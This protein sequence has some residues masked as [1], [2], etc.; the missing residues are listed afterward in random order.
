MQQG[1]NQCEQRPVSNRAEQGP[2]SSMA[3]QKLGCHT[4]GKRLG[5][6]YY[7]STPGGLV[8]YQLHTCSRTRINVQLSENSAVWYV[9]NTADIAFCHSKW[10]GETRK[11]PRKFP[12]GG[13]SR[14]TSIGYAGGLAEQ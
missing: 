4:G 13:R 9:L 6:L 14:I 11:F 12:G 2:V 5:G 7:R 8:H 3:E 10:R 1:A